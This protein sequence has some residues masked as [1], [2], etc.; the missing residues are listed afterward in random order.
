MIIENLHIN[1]FK[2]HRNTHIEFDTGISIIIGGNGAGKSSILEAASFALFKQYT[3]KRIE[4]LITIGQ[5]RMSVEIQFTTNG[6]TYRVLRERTRTSSKA[7]MKIKEGE[8]FQSLI[9]GD[10]QVTLEVQNLLEMDGDL[11]LNAVYVRQGEIADL[12]EKTS[13]EKK[14]MIGR[15]LGIDSLEKAWKNLKIILD[16]YNEQKIRLEGKIE[17]LKDL[18]SEFNSKKNKEDELARKIKDINLKI[19]ENIIESDL[20]REKKQILDKRSLEFENATTLLKSKKDFQDQL[21]KTGQYLDEQLSE[22]ILK[23]EEIARLNPRLKKLDVLKSLADKSKELK[24]LQKDKEKLSTILNDIKHFENVLNE[25]EQYYNDYSLLDSEINNLQYAKDQFEGSRVLIEQYTV[26]KSKIEDKMKES[27]GKIRDV[28]EESNQVLGTSFGSAEEFENHLST[29][30]PQLETQIRETSDSIQ[31]I[32]R[33][34]SNLQVKNENLEKPINELEHVKDLCPICKSDITPHIREKLITDYQSEIKD[35]NLRSE[36][37]KEKL[38]EFEDK[39]K[40]LDSQQSKIQSIN[41]EILKEY[42]NSANDNQKEID[43]I[44][45]SLQELQKKIVIL[46]NIENDIQRNKSQLAAIKGNYEKYLTARGSLESLGDYKEQVVK[47][48]EINVPIRDLKKN[49][50]A[51]ME[52]AGDSVENLPEEIAYLEQLSKKQQHLLGEVSQKDSLLQRINENQ[53]RIQET[54]EELNKVE[55]VINE[56]NYNPESHERVKKEW[57]LKNE[58]LMELGGQKQLLVG[59]LDQLSLSLQEIEAKLDSLKKYKKELKNL[60]DFL[61][62]LNVIRDIYSKDGVQ[63]DLRN[64]SRPL[65]EEKTRELF[66]KFN[67]EYSDVRLDEDYDVTIYGPG[68]ESSLDMISGGEKIAVALALRLGI[69][70]VLSGGTLEMIMLDEPTIHLDVYRRQELIDL[71]K[72]MSIIPQ[73][74]IVTHDTDL[75]D[76]ADNIMKIEKEEGVSFL[77]ES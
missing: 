55:K 25:N 33:E 26:R 21:E 35:N 39:K 30:K 71:L 48:E 70:Q 7:I 28:L 73:M 16:K 63:K 52:I 15:L 11:F 40:T 50:S 77:V 14:Q 3:S 31:D 5:K 1:N 46:E 59:Q 18:E 68:G 61:K 65:I 58:E 37:L 9:S 27:L 2:S 69:T 54:I 29:F 19:E 66:E 22:I 49:I 45:S 53:R 74:I 20:L 4:Q 13:S 41:L 56:L 12:I 10:K 6:R 36:D 72:K 42:L 67:F 23:E 60:K 44:N 17:S 38:K 32:K 8:R 51:L 43:N 24:L 75:E 62:L 47:L 34:L 76:A 57:D 64:L